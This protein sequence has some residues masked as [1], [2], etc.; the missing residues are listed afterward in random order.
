MG[1]V[2]AIRGAYAA[3]CGRLWDRITRH[4]YQDLSAVQAKM[5]DLQETRSNH[6]P[7]RHVIIT[8]PR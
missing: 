7:R 1:I 6:R 8:L 3:L 5:E 4:A 2:M